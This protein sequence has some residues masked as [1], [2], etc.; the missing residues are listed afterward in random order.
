M[1][2]SMTKEQFIR[3][4]GHRIAMTRIARGMTQ[5]ELG[6]EIGSDREKISG[7]ENGRH[8]PN[9]YSL[10]AISKALG[11]TQDSLCEPLK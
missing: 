7:Y 9:S 4:I 6:L 5:M 8:V 10:Y 3:T 11:V 2:N 1:S